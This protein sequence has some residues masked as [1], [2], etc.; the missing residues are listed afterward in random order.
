MANPERPQEYNLQ[1]WIG[2]RGIRFNKPNYEVRAFLSKDSADKLNEKSIERRKIFEAGEEVRLN[3]EPKED[4]YYLS[5]LDGKIHLPI[6]LTNWF[7]VRVFNIK[8]EAK[9]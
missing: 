1:H 4:K 3:H 9:E 8:K 5:D 2:E 7:F 6:D